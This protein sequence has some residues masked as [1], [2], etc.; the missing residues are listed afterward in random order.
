MTTMALVP[1]VVDAVHVPVIAFS[2]C[3]TQ[4]AYTCNAAGIDA[5]FPI[6]R[7]A[8]SLADAMNKKNAAENLCDTVEQVFRLIRTFSV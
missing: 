1:Q 4:E 5:F 3:V 2:G 8:V 6:Q 7:G